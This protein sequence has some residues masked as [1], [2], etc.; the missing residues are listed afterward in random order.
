VEGQGWVGGVGGG[1]GG[2]GVVDKGDFS[3]LKKSLVTKVKIEA[4]FFRKTWFLKNFEKEGIFIMKKFFLLLNVTTILFIY[5]VYIPHAYGT[6]KVSVSD[7]SG[8][9]GS[10]VDVTINVDD[11]TGIAGGDITLTYSSSILTAKSVDKTMLTSDFT[12]VSNLILGQVKISIAS[13]TGI[14]KGSGAIVRITFEVNAMATSGST[15]LL[16]LEKASLYNE[17]ANIIP[18]TTQNGTFTVGAIPKIG[19]VAI[20]GSPA[21]AGG[22]I[23]V[24]SMGTTG[25]TAKFSI[26][27]ITDAIDVPITESPNGTYTGSYEAKAGDDIKDAIVTVTFTNAFGKATDTS[28]TAT[29]DTIV[30]VVTAK[31]M[32]TDAIYKNGD[33]INIQVTTEV[34]ATVMVD[35]S[36][37]DTTKAEPLTLTESAVTPGMFELSDTISMDNVADN[38]DKTIAIKALDVAGNETTGTIIVE[39][40]N[41]YEATVDLSAGINMFSMPLND[42]RVSRLSDLASLIGPEATMIISYDATDK[43]FLTHMATSPLTSPTN[44]AVKGGVGYIV[45]MKA[46]KSVTFQGLTW[47]GDISLSA[48]INMISIPVN[49]GPW[50]LSD[51][52]SFIGPEVMMIISYDTAAKK[53]VTHMSTTPPTSPTNVA[54]KG[55]IGY[56]VMMKAAKSVTFTGEAWEM[57]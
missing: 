9:S 4:K 55:G 37:L 5:A 13:P 7:A 54:I 11:A 49:P 47:S 19:S 52:V 38:G 14:T 23:T 2:R 1:W 48:G 34:G 32:D 40:K 46:A 15:S 20:S 31:V 21:K 27:G 51:L 28:K 30:P 3:F 33:V 29:I 56:I 45:I 10:A 25:C 16:T 6:I 18:V 35:L 22:K 42:P 53:F 36:Q 24:T 50:R 57:P 8:I 39:L 44:V 17:A 26:A 41:F 12:F 43:K